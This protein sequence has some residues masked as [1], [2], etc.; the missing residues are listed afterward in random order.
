[1]TE[2]SGLAVMGRSR[3]LG[4]NIDRSA[5]DLEALGRREQRVGRT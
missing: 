4:V 5:S 3:E 2:T 1:V